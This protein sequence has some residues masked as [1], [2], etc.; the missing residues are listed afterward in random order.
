M[1]SRENPVFEEMKRIGCAWEEAREER[2]RRKQEIINTH[3]WESEELKAWYAEDEAAKFPFSGGASKAYRAW[4]SSVSHQ[5]DEVDLSDSLWDSEVLAFV[6]TLRKAGFTS[7][8][9]TDQS[10]AV[11]R[12]LHRFA[13]EGCRLVGLCT[14]L[15]YE[16]RWGDETPAEIPGIRFSLI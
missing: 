14:I 10:T 3:G 16:D 12:T 8:V 13:A 4:A 2:R 15:R 9:Y 11:M 5:E 7:F 6:D 1:L